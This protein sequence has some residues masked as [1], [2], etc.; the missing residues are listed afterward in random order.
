MSLIADGPN[1][2]Q[3]WR[4]LPGSGPLK[5]AGKDFTG[6]AFWRNEKNG[7]SVRLHP[8]G[9][10][11]GNGTYHD[12]GG[13][14]DHGGRLSLIAV[15]L[16]GPGA[17][18]N[19]NAIRDASKWMRDRYG[20]NFERVQ[21]ERYSPKEIEHAK[22]WLTGAFSKIDK[23]LQ[24]AK[25][26]IDALPDLEG[27]EAD[28]LHRIISER[29]SFRKRLVEIRRSIMESGFTPGV[30]ESLV[31][32]YREAKTRNKPLAIEM[33]RVGR[34]IERDS[35]AIVIAALSVGLLDE[36]TPVRKTAQSVQ[37]ETSREISYGR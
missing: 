31:K 6:R 10:K 21:R 20:V 34:D 27:P 33:S 37:R 11:S 24:T 26:K 22:A 7:E 17:S 35:E 1:I 14:Q 2:I 36:Q 12:F 9:G 13:A 15:A 18:Q 3:I 28:K 30:T 19:H 8:E 16:N 29:E 23:V 25:S 5:K 32:E 4:D